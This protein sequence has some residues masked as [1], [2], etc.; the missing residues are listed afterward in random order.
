MRILNFIS[1]FFFPP[2]ISDAS[3]GPIVGGIIG[4]ILVLVCLIAIVVI[5]LLL[6]KREKSDEHNEDV[7]EMSGLQVIPQ[8]QCILYVCTYVSLLRE[9]T[10]S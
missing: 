1:E 7:V 9:S 8:T 5:A 3:I 4:G 6:L 2:L 10:V